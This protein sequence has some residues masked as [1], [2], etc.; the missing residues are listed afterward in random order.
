MAKGNCNSNGIPSTWN[1]V[2]AFTWQLPDGEMVFL[3]IYVMIKSISIAFLYR[4]RDTKPANF[5]GIVLCCCCVVSA[6]KTASKELATCHLSFLL[7]CF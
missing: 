4:E 2:S 5:E 3:L 6:D 1:V 7:L